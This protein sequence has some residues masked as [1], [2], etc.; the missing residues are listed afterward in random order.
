MGAGSRRLASG[1]FARRGAG[2]AFAEGVWMQIEPMVQNLAAYPRWLVATCSVIVALAA[3][4]VVG[5]LLKWTLF[6]ILAVAMLTVVAG[7]LFWWL[8]RL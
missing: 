2:G 3:L 5:K 7:G 6:V 8:G 4:W 1:D